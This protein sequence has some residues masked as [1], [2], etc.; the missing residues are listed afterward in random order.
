MFSEK[1]AASHQMPRSSPLSIRTCSSLL[2]MGSRHMERLGWSS[3]VCLI[4]TLHI[5][6]MADAL[7]AGTLAW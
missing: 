2:R 3:V 5:D 1:P 7:I 4:P 6:Y